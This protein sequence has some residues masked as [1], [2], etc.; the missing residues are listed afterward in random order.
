MTIVD[1]I[2]CAIAKKHQKSWIRYHL[3]ASQIGTPCK[4][5]LWYALHWCSIPSSA[6]D[7]RILRLFDT[8]RLEEERIIAN[9]R[10]IGVCI[11]TTQAYY[12]DSEHPMISGSCDGIAYGFKDYPDER[13][14]L[15]FKTSNTK[16]FKALCQNGIKAEKYQHY[17]QINLYLLW[18]GLKRALYIVTC[19]ETDELYAEWVEFDA[20]V[21]NVEL[22][23]AKAVLL[24]Q[25]IPDRIE[26]AKS[27][28]SMPCRFC[29]YK[30]VCWSKD[31]PLVN[32]R[33]C[34]HCGYDTVNKTFGCC[35]GNT[36][37][38]SPEVHLNCHRFNP[39]ALAWMI[40]DISADCKNI[41][42]VSPYGGRYNTAEIKSVDFESLLEQEKE[43]FEKFKR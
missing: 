16:S 28:A 8:G 42:Y 18:S 25:K 40:G 11:E 13:V 4:R 23:K 35:L 38:D 33:T 34:L 5:A 19:K 17:V 7:G 2:Y 39:F 12:H 24:S 36:F 1:D 22:D 26:T 30:G 41:V 6:S 9:L 32:C 29:D 43:Q 21:A 10:D 31:L 20:D 14:L 3:G 37:V 15:E 27:E